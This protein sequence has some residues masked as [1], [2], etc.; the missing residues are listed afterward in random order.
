M[1]FNPSLI[2]N[3]AKPGTS[4]KRKGK[5]KKHPFKLKAKRFSPP[6]VIP[7]SQLPKKYQSSTYADVADPFRAEALADNPVMKA[8]TARNNDGMSFVW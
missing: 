4:T 3:L 2:E 7:K 8:T 6:L 1:A 5:R